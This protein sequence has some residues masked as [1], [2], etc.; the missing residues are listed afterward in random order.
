MT[1][2][3]A[4]RDD[5]TTNQESV[6]VRDVPAEVVTDGHND[7]SHSNSSAASSN[8][9]SA[10]AARLSRLIYGRSRGRARRLGDN[11]GQGSSLV[12]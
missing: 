12:M 6:S 11:S 10:N 5:G 1:E 3:S 9:G 2:A 7:S 4:R 8:V